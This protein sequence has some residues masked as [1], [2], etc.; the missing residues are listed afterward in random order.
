[1]W[2]F[3]FGMGIRASHLQHALRGYETAQAAQNR[4]ALLG[5]RLVAC[6]RQRRPRGPD[7]RRDSF[8]IGRD[9][10]TQWPGGFLVWNF[11]T[12]VQVIPGVGSVGA[13]Y[14]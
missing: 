4:S 5:P 7:C 14:P 6:S 12:W 3:L 13:K 2:E 8:L 1:M 9:G 10:G 11:S